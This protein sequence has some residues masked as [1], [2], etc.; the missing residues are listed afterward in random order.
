MTGSTRRRNLFFRILGEGWPPHGGKRVEGR[1]NGT[2]LADRLIGP[3][4]R[5]GWQCVETGSPM[6]GGARGGR[7]ARRPARRRPV[8]VE[9]REKWY[10]RAKAQLR[11]G[12]Y[13]T[14]ACVIAGLVSMLHGASL[15]VPVGAL[16]VGVGLSIGIPA[17]LRYR[18]G[19]ARRRVRKDL[20]AELRGQERRSQAAFVEPSQ[21][22]RAVE[23]RWLPLY[24]DPQ[25]IRV[26]VVG[27]TG[28]G[29]AS[30]L[31]TLGSGAPGGPTLV[32]DF[33]EQ[34][35]AGGL[36]AFTSARGFP[37]RHTALPET[38]RQ[39]ELLAGLEVDEAVEVL[40]EAIDTMRDEDEPTA[41]RYTDATLLR[42]VAEVVHPQITFARLAAGLRV[43]LG[44]NPE[45]E[46]VLTADEVV[47]LSPRADTAAAGDRARDELPF[48]I[49]VLDLPA[50]AELGGQGGPRVGLWPHSGLHV[51]T[52][53]GRHP[54]RK[55][56]VDRVLFHRLLHE[57]RCLRG[58]SSSGQTLIVAGTDRLGRR[59]VEELVRQAARA[60]VRLVLMAESLWDGAH[61]LLGERRSATVV[62][63]LGGEDA[64]RAA[65]FIGR[66]HKFVL[67]Q[68]T[69]QISRNFTVGDGESRGTQDGDS[70]TTG[71]STSDGRSWA[72]SEVLGLAGASFHRSTGTGD[73]HSRT[74]SRSRTWQETYNR[75]VT[76]SISGGHTYARVYEFTVEPTTLQ[77]LA[78]TAFILTQLSPSGRQVVAGDCNPGTVALDRAAQGEQQN[79]LHR[80]R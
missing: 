23:V 62:M 8:S 55:E 16:V 77:G 80:S 43:L 18:V 68:V 21:R 58:P 22:G 26:D 67:S 28:D 3:A 48:L 41:L 63:Q 24:L 11:P 27:G 40:V 10:Q 61:R 4:G 74:E 42:A 19:A 36:A 35:V 12:L 14:G 70:F 64:K 49:E 20:R 71:W 31:V 73:N 7:Q 37:V 79:S 34:H 65:E 53:T 46:E 54:R 50:Q 29:W 66:G 69:T 39:L 59:G 13:L 30:L 17:W 51:I 15:A 5:V 56:V 75:S 76:D 45:F 57:L 47:R 52:T 25:V 78:P 9:R 2:V 44:T 1:S 38:I 32:L 33:T 72:A 60:D 6:P